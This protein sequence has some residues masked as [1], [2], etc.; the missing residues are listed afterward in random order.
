MK[1]EDVQSSDSNPKGRP[2]K[3]RRRWLGYSLAGLMGVILGGATVSHADLGHGWCGHGPRGHGWQ[4][5]V[6]A[7]QMTERVQY[8]ADWVL[9]KLNASD[10]QRDQVNQILASLVSD[11]QPLRDEH[12]ANRQAAVT[13]LTGS[14]VDT[15]ALDSARQKGLQLAD[16]A[17]ARVL[18][19]LA[20]IAQVL[21]PEQRAQAAEH[22][23]RWA[24]QAKL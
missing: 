11:L 4:A 3:G 6:G 18:D 16:S 9:R 12:R 8:R 19:A 13:A 23:A 15:G 1:T 5:G 2:E 17:S 24:P 22:F 21:T 10:A 7:D 20:Q 14:Q